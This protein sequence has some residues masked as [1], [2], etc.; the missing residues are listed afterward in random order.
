MDWA[1]P[2]SALI[3]GGIAVVSGWTVERGR[4]KCEERRHERDRRTT[5][6]A[7]YLAAALSLRQGADAAR[8]PVP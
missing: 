7:D 5:L 4:W 2:A 6:Y 1:A 3:G 8:E